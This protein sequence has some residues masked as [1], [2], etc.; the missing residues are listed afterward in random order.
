LSGKDLGNEAGAWWAVSGCSTHPPVGAFLVG[1]RRPTFA[2]TPRGPHAHPRTRRPRAPCAPQ[3]LQGEDRLLVLPSFQREP[4]SA[5]PQFSWRSEGTS[6]TRTR[7]D[8]FGRVWTPGRRDTGAARRQAETSPNRLR[9]TPRPGGTI[10]TSK[11]TTST[12]MLQD[13]RPQECCTITTRPLGPWSDRW[14]GSLLDSMTRL[15]R[16]A[17]QWSQPHNGPNLVVENFATLGVGPGGHAP[18]PTPVLQVGARALL[19][20]YRHSGG[21]DGLQGP[22]AGHFDRA[23]SP[24]RLTTSPE[25]SSHKNWANDST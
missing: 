8:L 12:A 24:R 2:N 13:G 4:F 10:S 23:H 3:D 11:E 17:S 16:A 15:R 18:D 25:R 5:P 1:S 22:S 14:A 6:L 9:A 20:L 7:V 21:E 19:L